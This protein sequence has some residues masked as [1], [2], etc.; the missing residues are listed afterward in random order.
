MITTL[1]ET[2]RD[3][4]LRALRDGEISPLSVYAAFRVNELHRLPLG[5][6]LLPLKDAMTKWNESNEAGKQRRAANKSGIKRLAEKASIVGNLPD[7]LLQVRVDLIKEGHPAH[8]NRIR[9]T[10]LAFIR[11]TLKRSHH[12]YGEVMDVP[13][14]KEKKAPRRQPQTWAQLAA[15]AETMNKEN[16]RFRVALWAMAL[17]GMG[18]K[19]YFVDGFLVLTDR[20]KVGGQKRRG[21]IRDVPAVR[22]EY[23]TRKVPSATVG[24]EREMRVF[25]EKLLEKCGIHP[26]DLRRTYANWMEA[27]GIPRTRRRLYIGHA[28]KDTTDIYEEHEG[29]VRTK[30]LFRKYVTLT[31]QRVSD[32]DGQRLNQSDARDAKLCLSG[33]RARK[34]TS[35]A[36]TMREASGIPVVSRRLSSRRRYSGLLLRGPLTVA[37]D[38]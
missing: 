32:T 2:G 18:P 29:R 6:E 20:V 3:D 10:A 36:R 8:F 25:G 28:K 7:A 33:Q 26:Y 15:H 30:R 27:A 11:D 19:E 14:L 22:T 31:S 35:A 34:S 38:A 4:I 23:F 9:A 37:R 12:L 13:L 17:C 24:A 1:N 16:P 21:R 5:K